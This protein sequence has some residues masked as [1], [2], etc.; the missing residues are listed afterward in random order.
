[1]NKQK[2]IL[3]TERLS[4]VLVAVLPKAIYRFN[5]IDENKHTSRQNVWDVTKEGFQAKIIAQNAYIGK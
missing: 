2:D 5:L 1:M 3:W 4:I